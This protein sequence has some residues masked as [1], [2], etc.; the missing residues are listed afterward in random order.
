MSQTY[1]AIL[2]EAGEAKLANAAALNQPLQ[3]SKM[4]VGDGNGVLPNPVRTQPALIKEN[5]RA[6]LNSLI[7]D[8]ANASQIIAELV[9]PEGTGGWWIREMALYD[10]AGVMVAVANCPPSYKPIVSEGSG[11]TQVLRMVLIVSSTAAVQLKIDPS[12]VLAT[13]AYVQ[14]TVEAL[15]ADLVG[16]IG[17]AVA[18]T[19]NTLLPLINAKLPL[20]GG[21]VSGFVNF[22]RSITGGYGTTTGTGNAWAAPIWVMGPGYSGTAAGTTFS[23][24]GMY[25]ITWYRTGTYGEG[26]YLYVNGTA[27]GAMGQTGIFTAGGFYG[28]G[29]GLTEVPPAAISPVS[30]NGTAESYSVTLPGGLIMKF[31]TFSRATAFSEAELITITFTDAFPS[32]CLWGG[33]MQVN[34]SGAA[35]VESLYLRK[36]M[37]KTNAVI[38]VEH[39]AAAGMNGKEFAWFFVGK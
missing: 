39:V 16:V 34:T 22:S 19:T 24:A 26:A 29:T 30:V 17:Q 27:V 9:I 35:N 37:T 36:S 10:A 14:T 21:N 5:Y 32:S 28:K 8:P 1:Y 18:D 11:R 13:R 7:V 3:V 6:N 20:V 12:V 25:G 23:P 15:R 38:M 31:G 4:A 2:T 33:A